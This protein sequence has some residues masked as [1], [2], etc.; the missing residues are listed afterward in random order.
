[1]DEGLA[2]CAPATVCSLWRQTRAC[3]QYSGVISLSVCQVLQGHLVVHSV[4]TPLSV[5]A[6]LALPAGP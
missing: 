1:M 5:W 3:V 2:V 4:H 6:T